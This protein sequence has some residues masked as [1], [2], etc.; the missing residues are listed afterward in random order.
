M[1]FHA[2]GPRHWADEPG[3]QE[4]APLVDQT[5]VTSIVVLLR[6]I[7][8]GG[9]HKTQFLHQLHPSD[10]S[11][12]RKT[13]MQK[14]SHT[15]PHPHTHRAGCKVWKVE[16]GRWLGQQTIISS[17]C[18]RVKTKFVLVRTSSAISVG[19]HSFPNHLRCKK[20]KCFNKIDCVYASG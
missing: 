17:S 15:P 7:E 1:C 2:V 14:L 16:R 6:E 9:G 12:H 20:W 10:C 4:G 13:T 11:S 19:S 8:G 18:Y 3:L 5:T